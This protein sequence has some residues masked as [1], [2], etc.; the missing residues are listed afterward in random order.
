ML[1]MYKFT[2]ILQIEVS[3]AF[4]EDRVDFSITFFGI[5]EFRFVP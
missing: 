4:L 3:V 5:E 1:Y 2:N